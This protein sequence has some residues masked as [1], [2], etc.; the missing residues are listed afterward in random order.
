MKNWIVPAIFAL[1]STACSPKTSTKL[2]DRQPQWENKIP[3]E[4]PVEVLEEETE[5]I[6][7]EPIKKG[8][9]EKNT[10]PAAPVVVV[11]LKR[12]ACYGKCPA[13]ELKLYNDGTIKYH[14]KAN[15]QNL[16]YFIAYTG[17]ETVVDVQTKAETIGYFGLNSQYPSSGKPQIYDMP[18]TTTFVKIDNKEH[19]ITNRHDSPAALFKFE[20][21]IESLLENLTWKPIRYDEF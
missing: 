5:E 18:Q 20:N 8:Q 4:V 14:G 6:P 12:E 11:G 9:F 3:V 1:L 7:E 13:F 21:Y 2:N 16:G 10:I 15:V 19:R 17:K